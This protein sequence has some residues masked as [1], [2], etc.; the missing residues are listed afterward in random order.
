MSDVFR[1]VILDSEAL[2]QLA[3]QSSRIVERIEA[4]RRLDYRVIIPGVVVAEVMNG[5]TKDALIW[6][7]LKRVPVEPT[8]TKIAATA[9]SLRYRA[10]ST[11]H[12][13]RDLTVDSIVAATA[14]KF[15]PAVIVTA[16]KADMSLL[17]GSHDVIVDG[18]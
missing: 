5:T 4:A 1:T 12:K 13:K 16:D 3:N 18:I 7:V 6:R 2:S 15:E 14:L 17:V 9:G 11:R 8:D 10:E